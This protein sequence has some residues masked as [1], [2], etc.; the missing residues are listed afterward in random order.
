M[1]A[2]CSY[3][4]TGMQSPIESEYIPSLDL[5]QRESVVFWLITGSPIT[6]VYNQA[7]F[8][9]SIFSPQTKV[10]VHVDL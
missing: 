8:L 10:H 4:Q 5:V 3:L 7:A 6:T 9:L 1:A 2:T